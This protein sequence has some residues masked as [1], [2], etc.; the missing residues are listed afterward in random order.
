MLLI[1][2]LLNIDPA[3]VNALN[4]TNQT[5]NLYDIETKKFVWMILTLLIKYSEMEPPYYS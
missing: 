3:P 1:F 2:L 5:I 4:L